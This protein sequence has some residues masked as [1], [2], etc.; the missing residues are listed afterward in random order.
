VDSLQAG[1]LEIA[2]RAAICMDR[3]IAGADM[4]QDS[5]TGQWYILEVNS[6]PQL[7]SGSYPDEKT[8]A[9]AAFIE[10]RLEK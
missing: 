3:Q 1:V 9:F 5:N 10:R 7:R 8:Q 6:S 4:V 2:V